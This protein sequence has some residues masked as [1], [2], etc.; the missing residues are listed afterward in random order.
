YDKVL[1]DVPCSGDGTLRRRPHCW[2]SWSLE[3]PLSLHQKQLQILCRGLHL[4]RAGGRLVY[5]TCSMN[6]IEN[7]AVVAAA[8]AR[9][10]GDVSLLPMS[11]HCPKDLEVSACLQSWW[12]PDPEEPGV[13]YKTWA[14][15]PVSK[16][17]PNGM[18]ME[19]MFAAVRDDMAKGCIRLAPH[20]IDGSGFFLALFTKTLHRSFPVEVPVMTKSSQIPWRARNEQNHYRLVS[21]ESCEVQSIVEFYGLKDLPEPLLAEY[22][23]KGKLTQLNLVNE[24]LLRVLQSAWILATKM[25][26]RLLRISLDRM[27]MLLMKRVLPMQTLLS[28]GAELKGLATCED[29]L[30][31]AVVGTMD[32]SFWVPCIITGTGL[33]LYARMEEVGDPMPK[34]LPPLQPRVITETKEVIVLDKPSG[35]RTEDALRS[36]QQ[37]HPSAELVSRLDK[38]TSGC[39]LV[40]LTASSAKEFTRQ[41]SEAKV[42]K[43]YLAVV[44]GSPALTGHIEAPLGLV[45]Q[46]GGAKYRAFVEDTG[47]AASTRYERI[48]TAGEE[49]THQIRCHMAHAGHPLIGDTKYGGRT[50]F[51]CDRL[52]LH[53]LALTAR[54]P[55][56]SALRTFSPIPSDLLRFLVAMSQDC[57]SQVEANRWQE[58]VAGNMQ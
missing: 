45:Q 46:G 55:S 1:C 42:S 34:L 24:P 52:P 32:S 3:F 38:D 51:W 40:P 15:V 41:F 47:K 6:P 23:V 35:L 26:K 56:G 12:V 17:K 10:G 16:R 44:H 13:Y 49:G 58:L 11:D 14:D 37:I 5:S 2:K 54:D 50:A 28:L 8:L 33:E 21:L 20:L 7:E 36:I 25:T 31:G 27:R 29:K 39:L 30:G 43:R 57:K 22:N 48:W 18:L 4:L 53:C 9:F 19:T